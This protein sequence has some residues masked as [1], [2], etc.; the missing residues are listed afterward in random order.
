VRYTNYWWSAL[1]RLMSL[2][3]VKIAVYLFFSFLTLF[4]LLL[5]LYASPVAVSQPNI[6]TSGIA[7][8]TNGVLTILG[9]LFGIW[10]IILSSKPTR[11]S[12]FSFYISLGLLILSVSFL[13]LTG[14][15]LYASA[16]S[17]VFISVSCAMVAFF[18]TLSI[19][20]YAKKS[21]E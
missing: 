12:M 10:A 8:Y 2:E 13:T 3:G 21:V 4:F 16:L 9:I 7:E 17:L 19:Q 15:G 1:A 14:L 6:N 11:P 20:S 5:G 18:L